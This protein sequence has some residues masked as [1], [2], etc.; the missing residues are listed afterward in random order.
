MGNKGVKYEA[1]M[2]VDTRE[3]ANNY[4]KAVKGPSNHAFGVET[5]DYLA[6]GNAYAAIS[7]AF[8][9]VS[10]NVGGSVQL[11]AVDSGKTYT[12]TRDSKVKPSEV[13]AALSG[14]AKHAEK[15]VFVRAVFP[16]SDFGGTDPKIK[17][18]AYEAVV[19][20][21]KDGIVMY[22]H[23]HGYAAKAKGPAQVTRFADEKAMKDFIATRG[24]GPA[25]KSDDV[26]SLR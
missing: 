26:P 16:I 19:R 10:R 17:T 4:I 14:K 20:S 18:G 7:E 2:L 6:K 22:H 25:M 3:G 15:D 12:L 23:G 13:L 11:V 24:Q 8:N 5:H 21:G 9:F 1:Y